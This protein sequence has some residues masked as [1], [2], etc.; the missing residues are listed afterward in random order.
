MSQYIIIPA[1]LESTRLPKKLLKTK[2]GLSVLEYAITIATGVLP[3]SNI[4]LAT[5]SD[6]LMSVGDSYK[7]RTIKTSSNHETGTNRILEA[8]NILNLKYDDCIANLQGDVVALDS[9]AL[10]FCLRPRHMEFSSAYMSV[11]LPKCEQVNF[12]KVVTDINNYAMYF[13]RY[14]IPF[15]EAIKKVHV[16][17]YGFKFETLIRA[18]RTALSGPAKSESLEQLMWLQNGFKIRMTE[19]NKAVSIDTQEDYDKWVTAG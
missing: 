6:E 14:P 10:T 1:R 13:S 15:N 2:N 8:A 9:Q 11:E 12:V 7:I 18:Y 19:I 16:G 5:D 3:R 4:V 17:V